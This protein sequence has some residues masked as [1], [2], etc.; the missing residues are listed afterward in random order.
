MDK[1][2]RHSA[3]TFED[4]EH[5]LGII[6]SLFSNLASDEPSRLRLVA[7]FV[8]ANYEKVDRLLELRELAQSK[9]RPV[10]RQIAAARTVSP[11]LCCSD[12][13]GSRRRCGCRARG[14]V[15]F[16]AT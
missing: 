9:L 11:P 12:T 3:P 2:K 7:K 15:V 13:A 14:G 8:E 10:E 6:A 1:K 5:I 4:D 16:L